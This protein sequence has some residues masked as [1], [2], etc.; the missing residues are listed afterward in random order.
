MSDIYHDH[1]DND[2]SKL[3]NF[4]DTFYCFPVMANS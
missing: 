2:K 3:L 4:K 1:H